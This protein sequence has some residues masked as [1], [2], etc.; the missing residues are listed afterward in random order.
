M[1]I[2]DSELLKNGKRKIKNVYLI[3]FFLFFF[4]RNGGFEKKNHQ[5]S[6]KLKNA[7]FWADIGENRHFQLSVAPLFMLR[8]GSTKAQIN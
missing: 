1:S 3:I 5:F 4:M 8:S 2:F 7:P 6:W